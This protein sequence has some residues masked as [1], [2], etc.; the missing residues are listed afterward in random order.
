MA[1]ATKHHGGKGQ[2]SGNNHRS[3]GRGRNRTDKPH[4][5]WRVRLPP[6]NADGYEFKTVAYRYDQGRLRHDFEISDLAEAITW[7][8]TNPS[9]EAS[10][11]VQNPQ[12]DKRLPLKEGDEVKLSFRNHGSHHGWKELWRLRITETDDDDSSGLLSVTLADEMEWLKRSTDDFVY[13][14]GKGGGKGK[15][16]AHK[17]NGW[18][19]DEITRDICSR[20]GI[21]VG[22]LVKGQHKIKNMSEHTSPLGAIMKAWALDRAA[23]GKRYVI[24]METGA[25]TVTT[26]RRTPFLLVL[27]GELLSATV[28]RS[29]RDTFATELNVRGTIKRKKGKHKKLQAL[30]KASKKLEARY[31]VVRRNITLSDPV[32]SKDELIKRGKRQL[33]ADQ[34]PTRTAS[35]S[36]DGIPQVRRGQAVKLRLVLDNLTQLVYVKSATHN[37]AAGAYTMDL[38]LQYTDPFV[39]SEGDK[40]REQR[41]KKAKKHNRKT[42]DFCGKHFD[43]FKPKPVRNRNRGNG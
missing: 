27:G 16:A 39:D 18:T 20:Y 12:L 3:Q 7:D 4:N 22:K 32:D 19:A 43:P 36:T 28:A 29:I 34:K 6:R 10:I 8:D 30:V 17:P 9:L 33:A 35:I 37:V 14:K 1:T 38:E 2:S 13:K 41:C 21:P 31:G 26:L 40:I 15:P 24:R 23:T 11:S 42:P 25:I 5:F